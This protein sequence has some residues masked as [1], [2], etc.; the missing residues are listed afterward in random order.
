MDY[1]GYRKVLR[2]LAEL[3]VR[4]FQR[5]RIAPGMSGSGCH[6]RCSITPATNI[7]C[8]HGARMRSWD[9][10]A[11]HYT[12]GQ[13]RKYFGWE[14]ASHVTPSRLAELF[15]ERFPAIAEAGRGPT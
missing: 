1:R 9:L 6:W 14:D 4:G 10:L 2:M 15:V 13:E 5:L 7:S 11:A 8:R 3:H 12:T